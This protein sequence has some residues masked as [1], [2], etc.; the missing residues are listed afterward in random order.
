[1]LTGTHLRLVPSRASLNKPADPIRTT[2]YDLIRLLQEESEWEED[3]LIVAVVMWL[4]REG[5]LTLL[6]DV[7]VVLTTS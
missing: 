2:L 4:I 5:Y 6:N 7:E 3:G 1:M